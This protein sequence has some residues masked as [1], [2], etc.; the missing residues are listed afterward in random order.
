MNSIPVFNKNSPWAYIKSKLDMLGVHG[1][2]V[3]VTT[4]RSE[5]VLLSTY[6][7]SLIISRVP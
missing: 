2:L 7:G 3:P 1:K 6:V 5:M 4:F